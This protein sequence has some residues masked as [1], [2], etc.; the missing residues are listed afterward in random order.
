MTVIGILAQVAA[1]ACGAGVVGAACVVI[2]AMAVAQS[3][4][5]VEVNE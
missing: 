2:V 1:W 4:G 5:D 3:W